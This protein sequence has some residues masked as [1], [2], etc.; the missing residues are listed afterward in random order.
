MKDERANQK[1][2]DDGDVHACQKE[3][4]L[5]DNGDMAS[6][7]QLPG[8]ETLEA[9]ITLHLPPTAFLSLEKPYLNDS[10]ILFRRMSRTNSHY[11]S[12]KDTHE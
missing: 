6:S 7:E 10:A 12:Q 4:V 2:S 3:Q 5:N 8:Q 11:Q 1:Q 9:G